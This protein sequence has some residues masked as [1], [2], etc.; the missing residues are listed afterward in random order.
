MYREI[1]AT[2]VPLVTLLLATNIFVIL[3]M[4]TEQWDFTFNMHHVVY[5]HSFL[6]G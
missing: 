5:L 3:K 2:C 1:P 4:E 6:S